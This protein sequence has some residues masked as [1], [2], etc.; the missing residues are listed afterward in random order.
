LED[1][2]LSPE[3]VKRIETL[4]ELHEKVGDID[5]EY[6]KERAALELK[7]LAQRRVIYEQRKQVITGEAAEALNSEL[8]TGTDGVKGVPGFWL[9]ALCNHPGIGDFITE[10][11]I[12]ALEFLTD[13]TVAYNETF[14][15]FKLMFHF[16]ENPYFTNKIL[17]KVYELSPD[18][19]EEKSP[20]LGGSTGTVIT[21]KPSKDLTVTEVKKKQKAKSGKN[22]GQVRTVTR[23]EPKASFFHYFSDPVD[24]PEDDPEDEEENQMVKINIEDDYDIAHAIRTDVIP[25]AVKW[26]TGEAV[27]DDEDEDDDDDEDE[28]EEGE[29][30]DGDD[31][32]GDDEDDDEDRK[33]PVKAKPSKGKSGGG[34]AGSPGAGGSEQPECKQN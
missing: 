1:E 19:L 20:T 23:L 9:R 27:P 5:K 22:K 6:K 11:D 18:I 14:S 25:D 24:Y 33:A 29:A 21:W 3:V 8:S 12:P 34:F 31:D 13:V 7:Y 28:D 15:L 17:E 2:K 10:E 26:Y 32:D 30:D 16:A 4:E